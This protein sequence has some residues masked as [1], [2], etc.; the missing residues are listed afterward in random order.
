MAARMVAGGGGSKDVESLV[1]SSRTRVKCVAGFAGW[2]RHQ[3]EAELERNVW[4][5]VEAD[6]VASLAM[7]EANASTT[8]SPQPPAATSSGGEEGSEEGEEGGGEEGKSGSSA[9]DWLRDAMWSGVMRQLGGE[10]AA[11]SRFPGDHELI[12]KH[13]EQ[14]W[15]EQNSLLHRRIDMLGEPEGSGSGDKE[16]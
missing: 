10:Y 15:D 4:F 12:F 13:M 11:L 3:L 7:M 1:R 8:P 2:A 6:D 9:S 5:L 16:D 14:L